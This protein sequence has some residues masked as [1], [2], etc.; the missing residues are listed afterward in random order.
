[1][2]LKLT[3]T[4]HQAAYQAQ[5]A[6]SIY[7]LLDFQ[8]D[9][10]SGRLP[11]DLRLVLDTS[12][13]MDSQASAGGKESKLKLLKRAVAAMLDLLEPGDHVRLVRFEHNAQTIF[14]RVIHTP[15]DRQAAQTSL[16]NM[17]GGGGTSIK[18]GLDQV[19]GDAPLP[20]HVARVVLVT[21]G[22]GEAGEEALCE[23]MAFDA[24]GTLTWLVYGIGVEYND[25]FLDRL[26]SANGGQYAHLSD[27][28]AATDTFAKEIMVMGEIALTGL[29]F[30]LDMA[31]GVELIKADRI[32]PQTV[33]LPIHTPH[34]M[35]ADLGDVDRQRGQ[36][37][38]IQLAIPAWPIGQAA[39][40]RVRASFHVPARKLLN[41]TL[42]L[43]LAIA[44]V[45]DARAIAP[46]AEVL[47]T[48]QLAGAN[49]LYTLGLAE[50]AQG[51]AGA[52]ARTLTSAAAVYQH[53]GLA[54]LGNQLVTL[55]SGLT[56]QGGL[57]EEV[58]RTLTTMARG[59][60]QPP[61]GTTQG[62]G[63]PHAP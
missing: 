24:R 37:I 38:L 12:G 56:A 55:T 50:V 31:P 14:D 3:P 40:A 26:A 17:H 61:G 47:R 20:D 58:K 13:S 45:A 63:A 41:Q 11:L 7:A 35:S 16:R 52:G 15:Q 9:G 27:L 25:A 62:G 46:D 2:S 49:R 57:D 22:E 32:V 33:A 54:D 43:P 18:A 8:P 44:L 60:W 5:Q 29:V 19:C 10:V 39:V 53:L 6:Q 28:Q 21:D 59:A 42:D 34:Y 51:S 36:K 4:F 30:D 23:R 48:A 1:M